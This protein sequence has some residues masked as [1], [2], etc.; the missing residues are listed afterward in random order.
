MMNRRTLVKASL[1]MIPLVVAGKLGAASYRPHV[2]VIGSGA[3]GLAAALSAHEAGADV[4]I[5]EKM[6]VIGGNTLVSSGVINAPDPERQKSAGIDDSPSLF[7]LQTYESGHRKGDVRLINE[8]AF[9]ALDTLRWLES[10]GVAFKSGIFQVYGGLWPRSHNPVI[11]HGRGYVNILAGA[12]EKAGIPIKTETEVIGFVVDQNRV[13]AVRARRAG[14]DLPNISADAVIIATG[15]FSANSR[16]C[17]KY[18]PRLEGLSFTGRSSATGEILEVVERIDADLIGMEDIQCNLGPV[19]GHHR[20]GFHLDVTR[21][22]LVNREGLRF[23]PEDGAR[24]TIRDAIF[25][26][27]GRFAFSIV[28]SDGFQIMPSLFQQAGAMGIRE[29]ATVRADSL[30]GLARAMDVNPQVFIETVESYNRAVM[31]GYDPKGREKWMLVKRLEK[32]PF[33]AAKVRMSVHYTMGG[34]RIDSGARVLRKDGLP[35][36]GLYAAGE[37]TGGIHGENR[38][39][40]NGLLDAFVFGR[41][42]GAGAAGKSLTFVR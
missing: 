20:T 40:G 24:D 37:T 36:H 4:E 10:Y 2:V 9:G 26:Q 30:E 1:G 19:S 15:G 25:S 13:L 23:V 16:L 17:T 31:E 39:G 33:Y 32:P 6:P 11:S 7:A 22:I 38:L 41:I 3:A 14:A 5:L 27:P 28:D 12:C 21:Y 34:I 42:A 35:I 29:G 8:M 18:D